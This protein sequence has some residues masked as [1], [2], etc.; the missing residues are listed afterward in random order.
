ML[1]SLLLCLFLTSLSL[2]LYLFVSVLFLSQNE[3]FVNLQSVFIPD[4]HKMK[5][6]IPDIV[7]SCGN[8]HGEQLPSGLFLTQTTCICGKKKKEKKPRKGF[9]S[10]N[11]FKS[12]PQPSSPTHLSAELLI[13]CGMFLLGPSVCLNTIW[14]EIKL[15][16]VLP[17]CQSSLF[18]SILQKPELSP[19]LVQKVKSDSRNHMLHAT[20]NLYHFRIWVGSCRTGCSLPWG[21]PAHEGEG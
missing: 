9:K 4:V 21:S 1:L 14:S 12:K 16:P 11:N 13:S 19:L 7:H 5:S 18:G 20:L 15:S 10:K 17:A 6:K 2:A 3:F 8:N